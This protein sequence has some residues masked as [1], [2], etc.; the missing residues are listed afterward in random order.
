MFFF[1]VFSRSI[2]LSFDHKLADHINWERR[3]R[4]LICSIRASRYIPKP[5]VEV[6]WRNIINIQNE[7]KII[8]IIII[9][10]CRNFQT[11]IASKRRLWRNCLRTHTHATRPNWS[12]RLM[13]LRVHQIRSNSKWHTNWITNQFKNGS[14]ALH[15]STVH[16]QRERL[17]SIYLFIFVLASIFFFSLA[18]TGGS[19]WRFFVLARRRVKQ[20]LIILILH[21]VS[22]IWRWWSTSI[23]ETQYFGWSTKIQFEIMVVDCVD[24]PPP[25]P[26]NG[27]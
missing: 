5:T 24:I 6:R 17:F 26:P 27:N 16:T 14:P 2:H 11:A 9:F 4:K 12:R 8:M 21:L 22:W 25:S 1:S 10:F 15:S 20:L 23:F 7:L 3:L 13:R 18:A 19:W